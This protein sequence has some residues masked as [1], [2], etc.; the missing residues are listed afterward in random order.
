MRYT[1]LQLS[2][3]LGS[4][5]QI[6]TEGLWPALLRRL[7]LPPSAPHLLWIVFG[8]MTLFVLLTPELALF[9]SHSWLRQRYAAIPVLMLVHGIPGALA[10]FLGAFQ[11]SNRLRSHGI[12]SG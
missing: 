11:F 12:R 2:T 9:D 6:M 10:F 8:L 7:F 3:T 5:P 1:I 4:R